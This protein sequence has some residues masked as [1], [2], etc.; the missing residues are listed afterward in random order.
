VLLN[1]AENESS[2]KYAIRLLKLWVPKFFKIVKIIGTDGHPYVNTIISQ[3]VPSAWHR[4]DTIHI[5]RNMK[6][7][8][9]K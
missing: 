4:I 3:E 5:L 7:K 1:I 2:W 6:E 9:G 8:F